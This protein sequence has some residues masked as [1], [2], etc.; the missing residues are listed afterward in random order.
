[1]GKSGKL[2]PTLFKRQ[3][4]NTLEEM[5]IVGVFMAQ[6]LM[7][8]REKIIEKECNCIEKKMEQGAN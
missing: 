4:L 2:L 8:W 5:K 3:F 1:M 6:G 7:S